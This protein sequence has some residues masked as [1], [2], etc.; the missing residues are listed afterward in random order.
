MKCLEAGPL[1]AALADG[2]LDAVQSAAV[3]RHL[4]DCCACA[5]EHRCLLQLGARVREE[6]GY[7]RAPQS[8]RDRAVAAAAS[9]G[10]PAR[11]ADP[12]ADRRRWLGWGALAGSVATAAALSLATAATAWL[13][14]RDLADE[15]VA[16]HVRATLDDRLVAVAS[17]DR[18]TVRPWLSGRLDYA[19][20]V[21]DAPQPGVT[22]VGG[23]LDR[24]RHASVAA[25]VYRYRLHTIDV[26][27]RPLPGGSPS[28]P[29]PKTVRGFNVVQAAGAGMDWIA[30]SDLNVAQL[31]GLVQSLAHPAQ[32]APPAADQELR[33]PSR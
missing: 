7:F 23:R 11:R 32:D 5:A 17:S 27:V 21:L 20:P 6:A 33:A 31:S 3:E 9:L 19:P 14:R 24:L 22:L 8:L 10:V 15:A 29:A 30:V 1:L 16:A 28:T 25:L 26:F 13:D 4:M 12:S 2:E 18:H